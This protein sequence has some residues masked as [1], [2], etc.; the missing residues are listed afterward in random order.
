MSYGRA[1]QPMPVSPV[2]QP[3]PISNRPNQGVAAALLVCAVLLLGGLLTRGWVSAS[4]GEMEASVGLLGYKF[5]GGDDCDGKW[6]DTRTR[7]DGDIHAARFATFGLGLATAVLI[8]LIGGLALGGKRLSPI[9][10]YV[11]APLTL[12]LG[13]YYVVRVMSETRGPDFG[14]GISFVAAFLALV[15]APLLAGLGLRVRRG[16]PAAW[17]GAPGYGYGAPAGYGGYPAPGQA[18]PGAG[19]SASPPQAAAPPSAPSSAA[20]A[21]SVCPRCQ[22]PTQWIAQYQRAYCGRCQQY[23]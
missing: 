1:M 13:L 12:V 14:P 2:P 15:G 16:P 10:L 5:C 4:R 21:P 17:A 18:A 11:L 23:V 7:G 20:A 19:P 3:A 22:A 8:G 6:F 9:P